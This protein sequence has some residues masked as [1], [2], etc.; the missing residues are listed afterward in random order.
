MI[1]ILVV[2]LFIV[3]ISV[4]LWNDS[5]GF[6]KEMFATM[7]VVGV[8]AG[9][10]VALFSSL[11]LPSKLAPND[12]IDLYTLK[13]GDPQLEGRFFL[14]TGIVDSNPVW[15]FNTV[16]SR[17]PLT[18]DEGYVPANSYHYQIRKVLDQETGSAYLQTYHHDF[19]QPWF[20][21]IALFP[22]DSGPALYEF[23][24]PVN[25]IIPDIQ[26]QP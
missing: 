9:F 2:T 26:A 24:L 14:G 3:L 4:K 1:T 19:A 10:L 25:A 22:N 11:L 15:E 21:Y 8:V 5:D 18:L 16:V 12:R 13:R 6:N 17:N 20:K 7:C 23:H